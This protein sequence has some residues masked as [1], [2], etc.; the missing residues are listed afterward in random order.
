[1]A[2]AQLRKLGYTASA[3]TNGLEAVEA[4]RDGSFDLILMDCQMPVMDGFEATRRIRAS[5]QSGMPI[6]AVTADAMSEDRD[7]CLSEGM[8]DYLSKP[9][10]LAALQHMLAKWL[11]PEQKEIVQKVVEAKEV[12]FDPESLLRRLMGDRELAGIVIKGF[13]ESVPDQLHSLQACLNEADAA[14]TRLQA[15]ALKGAAATVSA[16]ALR[17]IALTME[18]AARSGE[19]GRCSALLPRA[20]AELARF[21]T[22]LNRDGW[23]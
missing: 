5:A 12:A 16:E 23:I 13:L 11:P 8:S 7:R 2:L 19:L 1:V 14:G 15:H 18:G 3:V 4:V 10:E 17:A 21:R 6:V 22:V 20:D 9:V